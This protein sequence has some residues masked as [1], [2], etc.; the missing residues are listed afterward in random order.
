MLTSAPHGDPRSA[1]VLLGDIGAIVGQDTRTSV[2]NV[3]PGRVDD[4]RGGT[5]CPEPAFLFG[6]HE[7]R[8]PLT[9]EFEYRVVGARRSVVG[10]SASREARGDENRTAGREPA[11]HRVP[12][13]GYRLCTMAIGLGLEGSVERVVGDADTA[14]ALGSGDV[15]LLGTPAVVAL[16]EAAAVKALEGGLPANETTV[17]VIMN[18]E[19]IA[20]TPPGDHVVARAK[21]QNIDGRKLE[22]TV[23]AF[24][25]SGQIARGVHVRMRV[26]RER[27]VENA[28][29]RS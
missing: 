4:L 10:T 5:R 23:E 1:E 3:W 17:G 27:F 6:T 29:D 12:A 8:A 28:C 22:F 25:R 15:D 18:I 7:D 2:E 14:R 21:L 19:H 11:F 13:Y 24:D 9:D 26:D 16:C 20:P